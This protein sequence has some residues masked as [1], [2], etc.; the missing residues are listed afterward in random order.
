MTSDDA[1]GGIAG[2]AE[3]SAAGGPEIA[4]GRPV[5]ETSGPAGAAIALI[6]VIARN[7]GLVRRCG[8]R[9]PQ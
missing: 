5:Q 9:I 4:F 8:L 2:G 3:E 1:D 6:A 7:R